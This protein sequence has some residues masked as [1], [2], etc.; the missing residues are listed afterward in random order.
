MNPLR[1]FP[2]NPDGLSG[3]VRGNAFGARRRGGIALRGANRGQKVGGRVERRGSRDLEPI[4]AIDREKT[5]GGA[6]GRRAAGVQCGAAV[7]LALLL[8]GCGEDPASKA[9]S[10][11][12][13]LRANHA[14]LG[15]VCDPER[16]AQAAF[17]AQGNAERYRWWKLSAD[18]TCGLMQYEGRGAPSDVA[19]RDRIN[20]QRAEDLF[21]A[22]VNAVDAAG[23][24]VD[25]ASN[26]IEPQ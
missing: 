24:E 14:T 22:S 18:T 11:V 26:Q 19:E 3:P 17:A 4:P 20:R 21:N 1:P 12:D 13:F 15:E 16:A 7:A 9:A 23:N 6:D 25:N 10:Q 2:L 5:R 8:A